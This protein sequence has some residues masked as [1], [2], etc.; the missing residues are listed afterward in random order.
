MT[1]RIIAKQVRTL[2]GLL[3]KVESL[4]DA[5]AKALGDLEGTG[6]EAPMKSSK[7]MKKTPAMMKEKA[8]KTSKSKKS[9]KDNKEEKEKAAS[10][11][12]KSMKGKKVQEEDYD[13]EE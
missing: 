12:K 1:D 13:E 5:I 11:S 4:G 2:T 6:E 10:K 7:G 8:S 9:K 3:K